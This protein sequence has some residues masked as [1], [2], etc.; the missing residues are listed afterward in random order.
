[1][2]E[3]LRNATSRQRAALARMH[4]K[5]GADIVKVGRWPFRRKVWRVSCPTCC[6]TAEETVPVMPAEMG[7]VESMLLRRRMEEHLAE[8]LRRLTFADVWLGGR[9]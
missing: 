8:A 3:A 1:M 9:G 6:W 7:L 5:L 4:P 2:H